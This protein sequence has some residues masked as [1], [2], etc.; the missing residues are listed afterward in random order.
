[1]MTKRFQY[2]AEVS[3]WNHKQ[4]NVWLHKFCTD[5]CE[6]SR[7]ES[8]SKVH[9][10]HYKNRMINVKS[11]VRPKSSYLTIIV[12]TRGWAPWRN[13]EDF[14]GSMLSNTGGNVAYYPNKTAQRAL[15]SDNEFNKSNFIVYTSLLLL[16]V[17]AGLGSLYA[18]F[19]P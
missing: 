5:I 4:L 11:F 19:C 8:G 1:M 10:A 6:L 9:S 7:P 15:F 14:V 18:Y 16:A 3:G 17:A 13:D 2:Q 12:T